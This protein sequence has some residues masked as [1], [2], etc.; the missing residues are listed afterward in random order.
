MRVDAYA[1]V[2]F[3]H[4]KRC[5]TIAECF[6]HRGENVFFTLCGDS[7]A[8]GLVRDAGYDV[9]LVQGD[10]GFSDQ[11]NAIGDQNLENA[12]IAVLDLAHSFAIRDSQGFS[13]YLRAVKQNCFTVLIDSFGAQSLR[14]NVAE[15]CCDVLVSPY[16]GEQKSEYDIE[17]A[18]F[19]GVHYFVLDS[20]YL[21]MRD[22]QINEYAKKLLITC[23][24]SDPTL[25][26]SRVL[27]ALGKFDKR[28]LDIKLVIGP[29]FS[30]RLERELLRIADAS[31]HNVIFVKA[32]D[33]LSEAMEWC[34][35][36]IATSGLTKYELAATGTPAILMSIDQSHD[37]VNQNFSCANSVID[38]GVVSKVSDV[39]LT[40][41]FWNLLE[42][43]ESRIQLSMAGRSLV[44]GDGAH[45]L[46]DGILSYKT[47]SGS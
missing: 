30:D 12:D 22:K 23:G 4:L 1:G 37:A 42:D 47:S 9:Y 34:D 11:A 35:L 33:N 31:P 19:L 25:V 40:D 7:I 6:R 39:D 2:G 45:N 41:S 24:G 5:L 21:D 28:V 13:S 18:E 46:V 15:L 20:A 27:N 38:L 10:A 36:A 26:S 44:K 17:Y 43:R 3:G 16:L 8:T 14:E 32:P 29:G